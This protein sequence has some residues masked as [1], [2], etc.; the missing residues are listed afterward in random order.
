MKSNYEKVLSSLIG[1]DYL[2][3][4]TSGGLCVLASPNPDTWKHIPALLIALAVSVLI[5]VCIRGF[6]A[7]CEKLGDK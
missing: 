7:V 5:F 4:A 1:F 2:L 3:I 6:L